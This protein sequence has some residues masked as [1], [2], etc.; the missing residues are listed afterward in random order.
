MVMVGGDGGWCDGHLDSG[1]GVASPNPRSL[2]ALPVLATRSLCQRSSLLGSTSTSSTRVCPP[3]APMKCCAVCSRM[4]R[5]GRVLFGAAG[6][7]ALYC[8]ALGQHV[9]CLRVLLSAM[10]SRS[11]ADTHKVRRRRRLLSRGFGGWAADAL[12]VYFLHRP[13]DVPPGLRWQHV[14]P[15]LRHGYTVGAGFRQGV[16]SVEAEQS[17]LSAQL[18]CCCRESIHTVV[19]FKLT[20][21]SR[22][23]HGM[24]LSFAFKLPL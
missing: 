23:C 6:W 4:I 12:L 2:S 9:S 13:M 18:A 11:S 16:C 19:D 1:D 22:K 3:A 17:T 7:S 14:H 15:L 5:T 8:A 10:G 21:L 20:V 24:D